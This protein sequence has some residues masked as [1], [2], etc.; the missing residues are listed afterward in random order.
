MNAR[1]SMVRRIV[2]VALALPAAFAAR[3]AAAQLASAGAASLGLGDNYTALAR[4]RNAVAWNPANLALP[5]GPSF[6]LAL[7]PVRVSAGISPI[8]TADLK[9]VEGA[10]IPASVKEEWLAR[11]TEAGRQ[12]GALGFDLTHLSMNVGRVGIQVASTVAGT[13][14]LGP[15]VAELLLFGNAGRT[16]EPGDFDLAGSAIDMSMTTTF[17]LSYAQPLSIGFGPLP[18]QHFALGATVKYIIGNALFSAADAGS[19]ATG[20]PLEIGVEF[21]IIHTDTA[22]R[23]N[24]GAGYGVDV[25]AAWQG[26]PLSLG[27]VLRNVLNTFE[28][29]ATTLR[30]TPGSAV[31]TADTSY[32]DFDSRSI[33][34]APQ[35]IRD[36]AARL[37]D[38]LRYRPSLALGAALELPLV[39][40]TADIRHRLDEGMEVGPATHAGIGAELRLIPF[41]PL[42]AGVTALSGGYQYAG[43]VGLELGLINLG[44]SASHRRS[45]L[46]EDAMVMLAV[47]FGA[48]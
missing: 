47:S 31:F 16:G 10:V 30:Y 19:T 46:G 33:D 35:Q 18:D 11:I 41:I 28:W 20:D 2:A 44:L 25:G 37:L 3:P 24:N 17:A 27:V 6:S 14:D 29:D 43:G 32:S 7:A 5:D 8:T 42:R 22:F 1:H 9:Q 39:T 48:N 36:R 45:D 34:D 12:R 21:P 40:L 26:G 38:E 23:F 4:G 15:D 13:V